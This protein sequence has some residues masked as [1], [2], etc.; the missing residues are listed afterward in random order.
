MKSKTLATVLG[1]GLALSVWGNG[2][3]VRQY[4]RLLDNYK[5]LYSKTER[6]LNAAEKALRQRDE[7]MEQNQELSRKL[8]STPYKI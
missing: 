5:E 6:A 1:I 4:F 8:N 7:L 3:Q 2:C